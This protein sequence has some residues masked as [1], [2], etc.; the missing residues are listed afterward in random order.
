MG[1]MEQMNNKAPVSKPGIDPVNAGKHHDPTDSVIFVLGIAL[2]IAFFSPVIIPVASK[3][4]QLFFL[5][6][7]FISNNQGKS[8]PGMLAIQMLYPL[9]AGIFLIFAAQWKRS[10]G[11]ACALFAVGVFPLVLLIIDP[12][13]QNGIDRIIGSLPQ[14]AN[15]GLVILFVGVSVS[16]ILAGA[17]TVR[18][19]PQNKHAPHLAIIGGILYLISLMIPVGGKFPFTAPFS[20]MFSGDSSGAGYAFAFGF[21]H[22]VGLILMVSMVVCSL[23]LLGPASHREK[24]G[25]HIIILWLSAL[26]LW[27]VSFLNLMTY[28]SI[29]SAIG[30]SGLQTILSLVFLKAFPWIFGL[31]HLVPL[32]IAEFMLSPAPTLVKFNCRVIGRI[33]VYSV[34]AVILFKFAYNALKPV[35][36][37]EDIAST[38]L[39]FAVKRGEVKEV[40]RLI[41][42]EGADV[43]FKYQGQALLHFAAQIGNIEIV[44]ELLNGTR[45]DVTDRSE[46]TPLLIAASC[47]HIETA[48]FLIDKGADVNR[49]NRNGDTVLNIAVQKGSEM[50]VR[51]ILAVDTDVNISNEKGYTPIYYAAKNGNSEIV[52]MLLDKKADANI[53]HMGKNSPLIEAAVKGHTEVVKQLL[54]GGADPDARTK[55]GATAL[56]MAQIYKH[57]EIADMLTRVGASP[58]DENFD[59]RKLRSNPALIT[60]ITSGNYEQVKDLIDRGTDIFFKDERGTTPLLMALWKRKTDVARLLVEKGCDVN[61]TDDRGESPLHMAAEKGLLEIIDLLLEKGADIDYC[62]RRKYTALH[63]AVLHGYGKGTSLTYPLRN[64]ALMVQKLINLGAD[65]NKKDGSE[66]TPLHT[67][68]KMG[69]SEEVKIL[70]ENGANP[71]IKNYWGETPLDLAIKRSRHFVRYGELSKKMH[72][73]IRYLKQ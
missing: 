30:G 26:V 2:L 29:T 23:R 11:K 32:G 48:V 41:R 17:Y 66:E 70:L 21:I 54:A 34:L 22:L 3:G 69:T 67:A 36:Q 39:M 16:L 49:K 8:I 45:V 18:I 51:K 33:V 13:V 5:N 15:L 60:A 53:R 62:D 28:A 14:I 27:S 19:N 50:L 43:N 20:M 71:G 38:K 58:G 4:T 42:E 61:E 73:I 56:R 1:A 7:E 64:N 31:F 47:G 9:L 44:K 63:H 57:R 72:L 65:V 12:Q 68:A 35:P 37:L 25:K 52:R 10:V 40:K 24:T 55:L 59:P 46:E 6:I